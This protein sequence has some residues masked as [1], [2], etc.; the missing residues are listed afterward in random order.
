MLYEKKEMLMLS[1][2]VEDLDKILKKAQV[3]KKNSSDYIINKEDVRNMLFTEDGSLNFLTSNKENMTVNIGRNALCQLCNKIK[4][5]VKYMDNCIEIGR[6]DLVQE[7]INTWIKELNNN[8]DY[9]ARI[10]KDNNLR[11]LLTS[12]YSIFDS[13]EI[14][15]I[16]AN[17]INLNEYEIKGHLLNEE[18]LHLRIVKK[19][20][21]GVEKDKDLFA[22]FTI[23]S[24]DVGRNTLTVRYFIFK[25]ICTNGLIM[26]RFN[27]NLL[28]QIHRGITKDKFRE[29]FVNSLSL[30]DDLT[31][32]AIEL[33]NNA[34]NNSIPHFDSIK[35]YDKFISKVQDKTELPKSIID[36]A[37]DIMDE[38]Y[39][40][41]AWGL[42]NGLTELAQG[43]NFE[44]RLNIETLASNILMMNSFV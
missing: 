4:V 37:I 8:S 16:V 10:Y 39:D 23:D 9:L 3:I 11:G 30:I 14:L 18:R 20:P 26:K 24:S 2:D 13:D 22:G 28:S 12:S 33:I 7:N 38:K 27:S 31:D 32:E 15:D 29:S 40:Q 42:I 21:I 35:D 44:N 34:G 6:T 25:Q 36:K 17:E 5:P 19:D 1:K 41:T 43:K